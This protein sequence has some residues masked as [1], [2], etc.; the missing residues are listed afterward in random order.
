MPSTTLIFVL[1]EEDYR[2]WGPCI[3][4][5]KW[6]DLLCRTGFSGVDLEIPDYL[7]EACH[8]YSV[9]VSSATAPQQQHSGPN[10]A[11]N[12]LQISN[13]TIIVDDSSSLQ[14]GIGSE[15]R[16]RLRSLELTNCDIMSLEQAASSKSL[17]QQFC[18]L[19]NEVENPFLINIDAHT[20]VQ[21]Q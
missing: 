21:L 7:D 8:E 20:P 19:L 13:I 14:R 6:H 1:G 10:P 2:L 9:I 5:P 11:S 18:I 4:T 3:P 16:D 15:L 12:H 17:D